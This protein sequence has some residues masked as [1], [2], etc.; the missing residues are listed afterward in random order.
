MKNDYLMPHERIWSESNLECEPSNDVR[1]RM[2]N[3]T[4]PHR[5]QKKLYLNL[6]GYF[7]Y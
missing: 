4:I 1:F 3:D 5:L 7:T 2:D 6:K